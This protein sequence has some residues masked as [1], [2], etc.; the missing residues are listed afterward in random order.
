MNLYFRVNRHNGSVI[1]TRPQLAGLIRA[2]LSARRVSDVAVG[3][4]NN[5]DV[6]RFIAA[7]AVIV[8]H[9]VPLSE[10][11]GRPEPLWMSTHSQSTLGGVA[12][13]VFFVVSG[14]LITQSYERT[15]SA[16]A[17]ACSRLL[18]IFPG[19][20]VMIIFTAFVLGPIETSLP[21]GRYFTDPRT[22][23]YLLTITLH[24]SASRSLPGV[25]TSNA[26]FGVINGSVWTLEA[27][28]LCYVLVGVLG[29]LGF[30]RSTV[31]AALFVVAI[32]VPFLRLPI[33]ATWEADIELFGY[34][35]AGMLLYTL[36]CKTPL[37]GRFALGGCGLLFL[38]AV[39]GFGFRPM[40]AISG[41]YI[42]L[43]VAFTDRLPWSR[44][45]RF[46]DV[47]YG[48]YIYAFPIQQAV[49]HAFGGS[50]D[51]MA[52]VLIATPLVLA[53]AFASWHLVE[54]RALRL[55][56]IFSGTPAIKGEA[57]DVSFSYARSN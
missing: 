17:F 18:R 43:W 33:R 35:A 57:T 8:S 20:A 7:V 31:V 38:A 51:P 52:N 5:F 40:V 42:I 11:P 1:R 48:V 29:L 12:V 46:G 44:F 39:S 47:S 55:K 13:A 9:S 21:L 54:K 25:F 2:T 45:A 4:V 32:A 16:A 28:V 36:R 23:S 37:I 50:M 56:K 14:F 30:L 15:R 27:E 49:V 6:I 22:Y 41:S 26:F 24:N 34:F 10:G 53:C 19:L 3:R